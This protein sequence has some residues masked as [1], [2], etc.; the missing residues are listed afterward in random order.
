MNTKTM[1]MMAML[2]ATAALSA[3]CRNA[4]AEVAPVPAERV[5]APAATPAPVATERALEISGDLRPAISTTLRF[6]SG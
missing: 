1:T 6:A 5:E 2:G 4:E 3:G